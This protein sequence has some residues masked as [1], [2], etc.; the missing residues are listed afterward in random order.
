[1]TI[2][3]FYSC[4]MHEWGIV[5]HLTGA[6]CPTF[7][8]HRQALPR[9]AAHTQNPRLPTGKFSG[10]KHDM[11]RSVSFYGV[12]IQYIKLSCE[13]LH[14]WGTSLGGWWDVTG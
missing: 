5:P 12:W 11:G 7:P 2:E 4:I 13:L 3:P 6:F 14:I 9:H 10:T 1:M 8:Y